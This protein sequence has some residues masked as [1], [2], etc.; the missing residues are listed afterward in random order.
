MQLSQNWSFKRQLPNLY[1]IPTPAYT[2]GMGATSKVLLK[3]WSSMKKLQFNPSD[4]T[5]QPGLVY[6]RSVIFLSTLHT[7]WFAG[8]RKQTNHEATTNY[9]WQWFTR[10]IVEQHPIVEI[11]IDSVTFSFCTPRILHVTKI[12]HHIAVYLI[13]NFNSFLTTFILNATFEQS[14]IKLT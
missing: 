7:V 12:L 3:G 10:T 13:V 14:W 11:C 1:M 4:L 2:I 8:K 9:H 5:T 6:V